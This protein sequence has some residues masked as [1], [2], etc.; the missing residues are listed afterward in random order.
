MGLFDAK[1]CEICG[2]RKGL[3]GYKLADGKYLCADCASKYYYSEYL[4]NATLNKKYFPH[5]L[6][7]TRYQD[8]VA[9][10]DNNRFELEEFTP[11]KTFCGFIHIDEDAQ[12]MVI[13]DK[14]TYSNEKK[15]MEANPPVFKFENLAFMRLTF[16]QPETSTTLTGKA[17]AESQVKLI[18]GFED[19]LYD[20]LCLE[21]GKMVTKETWRGYET[22]MDPEVDALLETIDAMMSWEIAWS[23]DHDVM[24]PAADMDAYWRLAARAK[25]LGYLTSDDIKTCLQNY[26]GKDR[27]KIREIKKTYGL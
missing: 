4:S 24:T 17:K 13:C 9:I 26:Y 16:T 5:D 15:R 10:R 12:E 14:S 20:I 23:N 6:T 19:P 27:A 21:I 8:L 2:K 7:L 3:L 18:L 22:K 11:S 1:Y 25:Q